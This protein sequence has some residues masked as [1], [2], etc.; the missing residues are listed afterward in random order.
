MN[1]NYVIVEASVIVRTTNINLKFKRL[2][3]KHELDEHELIKD[4]STNEMMKQMLPPGMFNHMMGN[5][6][7]P[8]L[9]FE[10]VDMMVSLV[11]FNN[12]ELNVGS[13]VTFNIP[14]TLLDIVG[15]ITNDKQ[16]V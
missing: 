12:S 10:Y 8:R 3:T 15:I 9:D 7:G 13:V 4:S 2:P 6:Q 16:L 5:D 1:V 14:T 11:E